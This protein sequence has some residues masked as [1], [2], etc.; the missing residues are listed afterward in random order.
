PTVVA[1]NLTLAL[2]NDGLAAI[3]VEDV[4]NGSSDNCN[5]TL[6]LDRFAF[7]CS[8]VGQHTVT[9]TG[10][11]PSGNTASATAT[12]TVVDNIAPTAIAQ[13]LEVFLD[14]DGVASIT[15]SQIDNGSSDNCGIASITLDRDT[16]GCGDLGEQT[17]TL[18]VTDT[19]GNSA[20]ATAT[21]T[22]TDNIAPIVVTK[23][24][25]RIIGAG[26][27]VTITADDVLNF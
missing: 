6:S 22:V 10:T 15:T 26:G 27:Q 19:N 1:Q 21:I 11:D 18:T 23:D 3:T 16:F 17:V 12:I 8:D 9:L 7:D 13:N 4:D 20:T 2:D 5:L 14:Q 25:T 24:I